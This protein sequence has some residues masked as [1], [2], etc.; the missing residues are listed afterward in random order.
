MSEPTT[1]AYVRRDEHGALRVADTRVPIDSIVAAF[2]QGHS[3]ETMQQQYPA[4]TLEQIYGALTYYL[5]H[6]DEVNDY[7]RGQ[8]RL[9]HEWQQRCEHEQPAVLQRL[10]AVRQAEKT[11]V[12]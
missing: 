6:A 3:P 9:W 10:R 1:N 2:Q 7:L 4:L 5:A 12:G 8:E 11:A